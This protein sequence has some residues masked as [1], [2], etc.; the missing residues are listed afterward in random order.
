MRWKIV[1]VAKTV[2]SKDYKSEC[3]DKNA[4]GTKNKS[5]LKNGHFRFS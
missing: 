4:I 3:M 5:L 1:K 2:N